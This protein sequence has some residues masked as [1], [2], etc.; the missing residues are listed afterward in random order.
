MKLMFSLNNNR[1][2]EQKNHSP[3][4]VSGSFEQCTLVDDLMNFPNNVFLTQAGNHR[5]CIL[6]SSQK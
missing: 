2:A 4:I 1:L 5:L 3:E 6:T